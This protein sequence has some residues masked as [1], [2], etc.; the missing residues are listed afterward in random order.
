M[1]QVV[2]PNTQPALEPEKLIEFI[3]ELRHSGFNIGT[4]QYLAVQ[5]LLILL[6]AQGR[7]PAEAAGLKTWLAPVVCSSPK[8]QEYFHREFDRWLKQRREPTI[9][10]RLRRAR[11]RKDPQKSSVSKLLNRWTVFAGGFF[12]LI[13]VGAIVLFKT[14]LASPNSNTTVAT[15]SPSPVA[16]PNNDKPAFIPVVDRPTIIVTGVS[17]SPTPAATPVTPR[18]RWVETYSTY[19]KQIRATAVALP[20][21]IVGIWWLRRNYRSHSLLEKWSTTKKPRLDEVKVGGVSAGLFRETGFR[22][23]AQELRRH[24]LSSSYDLDV[25]PTVG[26]TIRAGGRFTPIYSSRR[27]S[28][29]YLVLIDRVTYR[30]QLAH[31]EDQLVS[32]LV[33]DNVF[34]DR[35]YFHRDPRICRRDDPAAPHLTLRDLAARHPDHHLIVFSDGAGLFNPVS[36]RPQR[37]LESFSAWLHRSLLTEEAFADW[38]YREW[39]LSG[40]GFAVLPASKTG[41]QLLAETISARTSPR[42]IAGDWSKRYPELVQERPERWL[43]PSAPEPAVV[44]ELCEQL[45]QF[46]GNEDYGWLGACAVYPVL[47]WDL[48]L[49]FGIKLTRR[50]AFEERLLSLVRLPWFRHGVMPDWLRERLISDLSPDHEGTIRDALADLLITSLEQPSKG[51]ALDVAT[52]RNRETQSWRK[53]LGFI[54][55]RTRSRRL[56]LLLQAWIETEPEHSPLRDYVFLRFVAGGT[57]NKLA[58]SVP[59]TLRRVFRPQRATLGM[60]PVVALLVAAIVSVVGWVAITRTKPIP[61]TSAATLPSNASLRPVLITAM[62]MAKSDGSRRPGAITTSFDEEDETQFCVVKLSPARPGTR[63]K[64]AW[65]RMEG[66]KPSFTIENTEYVTP[67]LEDEVEAFL[68]LP[69]DRRHG[70]Y[71]VSASLNDN[72]PKTVE[73]TFV[74]TSPA[75]NSTPAPR[76]A[77]SDSSEFELWP[78]QQTVQANGRSK[79]TLQAA[80]LAPPPAG[81]RFRISV[82]PTAVILYQDRNVGTRVDV[83]LEDGKAMSESINIISRVPGRIQVRARVL[84]NGNESRAEV[85]FTA[86]HPSRIIFDDEPR[87]I[88][89]SQTVFRIS[90][91]L[92]DDDGM[93]VVADRPITI[94]LFAGRDDSPVVF[95]PSRVVMSPGSS[96]AQSMLRLMALPNDDLTLLAAPDNGEIKAARKTMPIRSNVSKVGLSG[97]TDV[98]RGTSAEFLIHLTDKDGVPILADWDRRIKLKSSS[99]MFVPDQVTIPKGQDRAKVQYLST[100]PTGR[101][102]LTAE[103]KGLSEGSLQI[104]VRL[105]LYWLMLAVLLGGLAGGVVRAL[106]NKGS[107]TMRILPTWTGKRWDVGLIGRALGT[108]LSAV[109]FYLVLKL[110]LSQAPVTMLPAALSLSSP[111]VA[112]FLGGIAGFAGIVLIERFLKFSLGALHQE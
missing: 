88:M 83:T 11:E 53:A 39:A 1:A 22:R 92:A 104:T 66:N 64:F 24:R 60:R 108:S 75:A 18:K 62:Y 41:L 50:E 37:W 58:V 112:F 10:S 77:T 110:A 17:S 69:R 71:E 89:L 100:N 85:N 19:F 12:L 56:K 51:F 84:P 80:F 68:S 57:A 55:R 72:L 43:D 74:L 23:I 46:L 29:E 48:T 99:G 34:V 106:T 79:A 86:P 94:R 4:Q 20:F 105:A 107:R 59:D 70:K 28:P 21:L 14:R 27:V 63:I 97:P 90:V 73:Y 78:D 102:L 7:L 103:S 42:T 45:R 76:V 30:D 5:D 91:G 31:L 96:S 54:G 101:V 81:T 98:T 38:G 109:S 40:L 2:T 61:I 32:R 87:E 9:R 3:D 26:A 36:G 35:Y 111:V 95:E 52:Q 6:A 65:K 93:P 47:Q 33:E 16:S 67:G 15:A 13:T 44:D 8:E 49:Y 82:D 25:Q